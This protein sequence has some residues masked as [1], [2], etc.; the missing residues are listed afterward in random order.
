M[1]QDRRTL[2]PLL[3]RERTVD[4]EKNDIVQL[5]GFRVGDEEYAIGIERIKEII[6]PPRDRSREGT[7]GKELIRRVPKAPKFVEGVIELRGQVIPV[8]D[9]RKRFELPPLTAEEM[10][11]HAIQRARKYL[12]VPVDERNQVGLI[13][14]RVSDV[15]RVMRDTVGPPPSLTQNE[16]A[17][18]FAGVCTLRRDDKTRILMVLALDSL[19]S[20]TE[21]SNLAELN[22]GAKGAST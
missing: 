18:Y 7:L 19:L 22:Q 11:D 3:G 14:D 9:L 12:I 17:R 6:N 21:K 16:N 15:L 2:R 10:T 13:V 4:K 8:I 20:S 5:C 1:S